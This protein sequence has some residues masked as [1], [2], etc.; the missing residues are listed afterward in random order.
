[1]TQRLQLAVICGGQSPEHPVSVVSARSILRE[2]DP[3]R[4][5]VVPFGITRGGMWL[6]PDETRVRLARVEAGETDDL[7]SEEPRG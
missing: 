1:M 3:A 5:E 7:G 2:A 4:F 6:T